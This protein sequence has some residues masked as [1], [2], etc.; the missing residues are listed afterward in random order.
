MKRLFASHDNQPTWCLGFLFWCCRFKR[1]WETTWRRVLQLNYILFLSTSHEVI[2]KTRRIFSWTPSLFW[3]IWNAALHHHHVFS[4]RFMHLHFIWIY[5]CHSFLRINLLPLEES[6]QD[7]TWTRNPEQAFDLSS[8][9]DDN[10]PWSEGLCANPLTIH[11]SRSLIASHARHRNFQTSLTKL[12]QCTFG[13]L[14][15]H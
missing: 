5:K 15:Q 10:M 8:L 13:N 9:S 14:H 1:H 2:Q 7:Q 12:M 3:T 6:A 11:G 4:L